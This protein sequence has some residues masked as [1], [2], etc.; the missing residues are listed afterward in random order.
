MKTIEKM[1]LITIILAGFIFGVSFST[2]YAQ[3]HIYEGTACS[4]TL[5]IPVLIPTFSSLGVFVGSIVYYL[6][7][8]KIEENKE[9]VKKDL[10]TFL[11]LLPEMEKE[12]LKEI[13]QNNGKILQSKISTKFGKVKAFRILENL[14][15]RGIIEKE[16]Y[17]K[18]NII[19]ISEKF[20]RILA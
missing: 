8:P 14:R 6:M 9:K 2:L 4:C 18:T 15:I 13:I 16:E 11:E 19:K 3:V 10:E 20:A 7:F 1:I 12:V 5:P 17:G